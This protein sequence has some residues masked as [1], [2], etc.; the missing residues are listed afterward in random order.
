ML[1]FSNKTKIK[2]KRQ[3]Q[4]ATVV[5]WGESARKGG[6]HLCIVIKVTQDS[7]GS[8]EN[9]NAGAGQRVG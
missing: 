5:L 3:T 9:W 2:G 6:K 8:F 7:K 4:A 1:L